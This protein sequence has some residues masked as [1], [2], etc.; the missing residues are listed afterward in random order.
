MLFVGVVPTLNHLG[1][2]S[3]SS[4]GDPILRIASIVQQHLPSNEVSFSDQGELGTLP[5]APYANMPRDF[6]TVFEPAEFKPL[7]DEIQRLYKAGRLFPGTLT[8]IRWQAIQ[9]WCK[10][11]IASISFA[12]LNLWIVYQN[13]VSLSW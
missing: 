12:M 9:D 8:S 3:A 4:H 1:L 7:W 2:V 5:G 6:L 11:G 10:V 13:G